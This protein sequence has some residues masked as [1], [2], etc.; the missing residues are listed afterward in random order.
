MKSSTISPAALGALAVLTVAIVAPADARDP[1]ETETLVPRAR[2]APLPGVVAD[3]CDTLST[4]ASLTL[5]EAIHTALCRNPQTRQTWANARIA[6][7]EVGIARS[8]YLPD[9][10]ADASLARTEVRNS[11][12]AGAETGLTV[13]ATLNYLLFDFGARDA[14]V[15][16]ARESLAAAN[17]SHNA[18]LQQVVYDTVEAYYLV[19]ANNENVVATGVAVQSA[20]QSLDAAQAR[21]GAGRGTRA[22][23]LQAQTALSQA[24][25]NRTRAEGDAATARGALANVLG[26]PTNSVLNLTAPPPLAELDYARQ[27]IEQLLDT[28]KSRRPELRAAEAEIRAAQANVK[29]SD[30]AGRPVVSAFADLSS[31]QRS[32]GAD[33]RSGAVGLT[34]NIPL[35]TGFRHTYQR[36]AAREQVI[37]S[38]ASRERLAQEIALDVWRAYQTM[39]TEGQAYETS[40]DLVAS[41]QEAYQAALARYRAGVGTLIDVLSAQSAT[42]DADFQKIQSQFRWYISKAA[43]ARSLGTL[44]AGL[45]AQAASQAA[46]SR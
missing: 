12:L 17:W 42:A 23:M 46:P 20:R 39:Q 36:R 41:A 43:L 29:A 25:L 24:Q 2:N 33:P 31:A 18:S 4:P 3:P 1:F 26:L 37:A 15:D 21:L 16:S 22:E 7:A 30:A 14:A 44:D 32:P 40:L 19:F 38:E 10:N 5:V 35:F 34:L 28:A 13:G 45:F 11:P 6:V 8:A 9:L 27:A